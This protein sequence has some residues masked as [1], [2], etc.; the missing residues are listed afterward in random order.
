MSWLDTVSDEEKEK[1]LEKKKVA[2]ENFL[3]SQPLPKEGVICYFGAF[4]DQSY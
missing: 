1:N 3:N 2:P 4:S